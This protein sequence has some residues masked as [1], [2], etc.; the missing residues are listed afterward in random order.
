AILP[1]KGLTLPFVSF[2]G[3][4]LLVNSIAAGILLN[5]S[6]QSP[7]PPVV[8]PPTAAPPDEPGGP[9]PAG[10]TWGVQRDGAPEPTA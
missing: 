9:G 10:Q 8:I 4:S 7:D 2:G 6:A 5:V 1:T 3:S